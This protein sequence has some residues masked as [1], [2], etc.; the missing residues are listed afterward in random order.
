MVVYSCYDTRIRNKPPPHLPIVSRSGRRNDGT[1]VRLGIP[2]RFGGN[3]GMNH[4]KRPTTPES[5][6]G[7][8]LISITNAWVATRRGLTMLAAAAA[9]LGAAVPAHGHQVWVETA[10]TA[11][12]GRPH[13]VQVCWGHSG[14]KE[15]GPAL[16][17]QASKLTVWVSGPDKREPLKLTAGSDSF[18]A[19]FTPRVPGCHAVGADLQV[20]IIDREFH[21]MPANTRI[22]M[23][24]KACTHLGEG[25]GE[26]SSPLGF[27]LE[28]VPGSSL[29]NAKPGDA[30]T[31]KVLHKGRPIGGRNVLVSLQT[32]GTLP[33]VDDARI[34]TR[35]WSIE[36]TADPST[37]EVAFPLIVGGQ[38][39]FFV[40]YFDE[41]PGTYDG[42]RNDSSEFSHLRKGDKFERTM[43]VSTLTFRVSAE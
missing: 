26:R 43:Y 28:I 11:V 7:M 16:T 8:Q 20:G 42:D 17:R 39:V 22:V 40:K 24:G 4:K 19:A 31:V 35:Q 18:T 5:E 12:T 2:N 21:G 9:S 32:S 38:H 6:V 41:T 34:Q 10:S 29:R 13:E 25:Q 1:V 3:A 14:M 15:G 36:S 33:P 30:V 37:G 27:D 23:Y